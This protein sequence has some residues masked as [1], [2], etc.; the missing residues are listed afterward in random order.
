MSEITAPEPRAV[1]NYV[2]GVG[3]GKYQVDHLN[4]PHVHV[5]DEAG[6][7][8]A[9]KTLVA[10]SKSQKA[11][12]LGTFTAIKYYWVAFLW[13]QYC[14]IG[15]LL[16]GYDGTVSIPILDFRSLH[17]LKQANLNLGDWFSPLRT[18]LPGSVG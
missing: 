17:R 8:E 4:N 16:V 3:D 18:Y 7:S 11:K 5:E 13:S 14:S 6:L 1:S 10:A 2:E 9:Q 15:A 12:A